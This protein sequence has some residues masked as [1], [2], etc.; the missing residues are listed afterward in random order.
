MADM[1]HLRKKLLINREVQG[2]IIC[3]TVLHWF[4]YLTAIIFTVVICEVWRDPSKLAIK[5]VFQSF[6]YF[7]PAVIASIILLPAVIYD[8]LKESNRVAGPIYRLRCEM[9]KLTQTG[10]VRNL[11]FRDGDHWNEMADTFNEL[12]DSHQ[13]LQDELNQLKKRVGAQTE[14]ATS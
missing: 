9:E 13:A 8:T 12:A 11:R 3:K 1:K 6:I 7:A 2:A 5:L 4:F 10:S 14:S